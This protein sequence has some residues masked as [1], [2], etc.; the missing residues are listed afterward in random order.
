MTYAEA[1]KEAD[2]RNANASSD[3][4]KWCPLTNKRCRP[5]CI[6]WNVSKPL[7]FGKHCGGEND[8]KE[9]FVVAG[10]GGCANQMFWRECPEN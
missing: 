10:F 8:G 1:K 3:A 5:A 2:K 6:C 7:L 4:N 9:N